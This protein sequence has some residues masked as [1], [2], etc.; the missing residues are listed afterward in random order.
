[1]QVSFSSTLILAL[2]SQRHE[3]K[4]NLTYLTDFNQQMLEDERLRIYRDDSLYYNFPTS[5]QLIPI[6]SYFLSCHSGVL[7]L[8]MLTQSLPNYD[9]LKRLADM[10]S[11]TLANND[12]YSLAECNYY[13]LLGNPSKSFLVSVACLKFP[14]LFLQ[15]IISNN[16]YN[17]ASTENNF[18]KCVIYFVPVPTHFKPPGFFQIK[19]GC[20]SFI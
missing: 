3:V 6:R 18:G 20:N 2:F 12:F 17:N 10:T 16:A 5:F 15:Y 11:R 7:L 19:C 4:A 13:N 1:M 14:Y 8:R 9:H